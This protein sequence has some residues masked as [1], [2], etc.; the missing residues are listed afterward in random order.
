MRKLIFILLIGSILLLTLLGCGQMNNSNENTTPDNTTESTTPKTTTPESTTPEETTPEE[1]TTEEIT[2]EETTPEETTLDETTPS[3]NDQDNP[4]LAEGELD[5]NSDLIVTLVNYL[6]EYWL[7]IEP[8][9]N[10]LETQIDKIKNGT[11]PLHVTF[12]SSDYY[13][14]CGYY[15]GS[16]QYE[17][18]M[19]CCPK[20]YTW[21]KYDKEDEIQEYDNGK[22][23]VVVFQMNRASSV[24]DILEE[25][26]THQMEHFQIYSPTFENGVNTK[27]SL[28][29]DKTFIYLH[30]SDKE[31]AYHSMSQYYNYFNVISCVDLDGQYYISV[32]L[33]TLK[34]D[35]IFDSQEALLKDSIL[36]DFGKY[37]DALAGVID[38]E[39]YRVHSSDGYTSYYGVISIEDFVNSVLK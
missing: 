13:F 12:D 11:K 14:V 34:E 30:D 7:Q 5:K 16:H 3:E 35:A 23:C 2:P 6:K 38:T 28:V 27:S 26:T 22:A 1:T 17:K 32:L 9:P 8:L 10:S 18:S 4:P 39:K 25:T 15:A 29:F 36:Y 33:A 21:K 20:E 37:Y 19:W 24:T 31:V